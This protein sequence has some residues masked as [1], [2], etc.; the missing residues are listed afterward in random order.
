MPFKPVEIE[1][2]A[3]LKRSLHEVSGGIEKNLTADL[4]EAARPAKDIAERLALSKI[5]GMKRSRVHWNEMRLGVSGSIVYIAPKQRGAKRTPA[6]RRPNLS[7]LIVEKAI[8][9]ALEVSEHR[10][11]AGAQKA[12]DR[13]I[14]AAGF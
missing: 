7:S 4:K 11:E 3:Q 9:P 6:R 8:N 13:A 10:I 12:V 1:G 14:R 2:L 5:S